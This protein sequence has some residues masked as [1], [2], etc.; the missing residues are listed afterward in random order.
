MG[1][2]T[3]KFECKNK[4]CGY[5]SGNVSNFALMR[6]GTISSIVIDLREKAIVEIG[7]VYSEPIKPKEI[8]DN[9]LDILHDHD[10]SPQ[11]KKVIK[12]E[13]KEK[14]M[15]LKKQYEDEMRPQKI[16]E[17]KKK[18]EEYS[19]RYKD[20]NSD[21]LLKSRMGLKDKIA[22]FL[23]TKE[24]EYYEMDNRS[25]YNWESLQ[26]INCSKCGKATLKWELVS[27]LYID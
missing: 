4:R 26:Y 24:K 27:Y 6:A 12:K 18:R 20:L 2:A 19:K 3:Y 17:R 25:K 10:L 22:I 15:E 8:N 13:E 9:L 11:E 21:D 23:R 7:N 1:K 16:E 14:Y 5:K